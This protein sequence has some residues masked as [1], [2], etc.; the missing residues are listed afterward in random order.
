ME[1]DGEGIVGPIG[2]CL[3]RARRGVLETLATLAKRGDEPTLRTFFKATVQGVQMVNFVLLTTTTSGG[4]TGGSRFAAVANAIGPLTNIFVALG[5]NAALY[6]YWA[7]VAWVAIFVALFAFCA[8]SFA[9]E[10]FTVLWPLKL[11]TYVASYSANE[12]FIPLFTSLMAGFSCGQGTKLDLWGSVGVS[13]VSGGFAAQ[14]VVTALLTIV[15]V[16]LCFTFT[17]VY[18]DSDPCSNNISARAHGRVDAI[19]LAINI[20]LVL[21]VRRIAIAQHRPTTRNHLPT[22]APPQVNVF[23][24]FSSI[25]H[26][27][28]FSLCGVA[29][30]GAYVF[31]MPFYSAIMNRSGC[32]VSALFLWAVAC[33]VMQSQGFVNDAGY[34]FLVGSPLALLSGLALFSARANC[35]MRTPP[36]RLLS[37]CVGCARAR[38]TPATDSIDPR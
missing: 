2:M 5:N 25:G 32:A 19:F 12:V 36:A 14:V 29:W 35:V 22:Y 33:Y 23:P 31:F 3:R 38:A 28:I 11:L 27:F 10:R 37:P 16:V 30:L 1:V 20:T 7:S 24:N 21:T 8:F 34:F 6:V 15:F 9:T 18:F 13:C 17:L 4:G 26:A